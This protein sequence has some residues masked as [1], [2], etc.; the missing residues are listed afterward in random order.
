[1]SVYGFTTRSLQIL[2]ICKCWSLQLQSLRRHSFVH[3]LHHTSPNTTKRATPTPH[4]VHLIN[5]PRPEPYS[6]VVVLFSWVVLHVPIKSYNLVKSIDKKMV[7][8]TCLSPTRSYSYCSS[9]LAHLENLIFN[10]RTAILLLGACIGQ[11][12]KANKKIQLRT[13]HQNRRKTLKRA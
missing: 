1:M 11:T 4:I 2:P 3:M 12:Y 8:V 7:S 9:A 13:I 10:L 6:I 5:Q